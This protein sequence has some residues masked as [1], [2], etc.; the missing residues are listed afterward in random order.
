M[1]PEGSGARGR[2]EQREP[3]VLAGLGVAEAVFRHIDAGTACVGDAMASRYTIIVSFQ[4]IS[5]C[6]MWKAWFGD[7]CQ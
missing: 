1:V 5:G 6:E 3:G 4:P 2:I 7:Q